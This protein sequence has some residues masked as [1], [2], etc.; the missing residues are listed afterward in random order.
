[1]KK[2]YIFFSLLF[3]CSM[4]LYSN[5][6]NEIKQEK[7]NVDINFSWYRF[8]LGDSYSN[9]M[10][11]VS[12]IGWLEKKENIEEEMFAKKPL[13]IRFYPSG[14]IEDISLQF[15]EKDT[16]FQEKKR[17]LIAIRVVYSKKSFSYNEIYQKL[18]NKY[19]KIVN[20][21]KTLSFERVKWENDT[22]SLTFYRK[23]NVVI[24]KK[25]KFKIPKIMRI[26]SDKKKKLDFF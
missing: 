15:E 2:V 7:E 22:N 14:S 26:N 16:N 18:R 1:M 23:D 9:V 24:Y 5:A 8:T 6:N 19:D 12:R 13:N 11:N 3:L 25:K 20:I 4:R 10:R 21:R 17:F